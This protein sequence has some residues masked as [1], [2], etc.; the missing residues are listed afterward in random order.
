MNTACANDYNMG[1]YNLNVLP[2]LN[3]GDILRLRKQHPCGGNE[4]Q[5]VRL[6]ADIGIE[7][8]RCGHRTIMPRRELARRVKTILPGE[9]RE[10]SAK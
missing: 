7:C 8:R 2:D 1:W 6:G 10:P 4:W 3:L 9:I 5:V